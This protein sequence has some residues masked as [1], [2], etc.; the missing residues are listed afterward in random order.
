MPEDECQR[1][2]VQKEQFLR[3]YGHH[4]YRPR[5]HVWKGVLKSIPTLERGT[6]TPANGRPPRHK[7]KRPGQRIPKR[8]RF[9]RTRTS[10]CPHYRQGVLRHNARRPP[11][12]T[13]HWT[14]HTL[15]H[16]CAFPGIADAAKVRRHRLCR[17]SPNVPAHDGT[18]VHHEDKL[19]RAIPGGLYPYT[20]ESNF[21]HQLT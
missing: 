6:L 9:G 15:G 8:H 3:P 10:T 17:N 14:K 21:Q 7:S 2:F 1:V 11:Y 20:G 5:K 13:R 4:D 18:H 16:F 19:L 12:R